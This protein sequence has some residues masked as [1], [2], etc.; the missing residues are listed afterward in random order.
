MQTSAEKSALE[1]CLR[2][3]AEQE[4]GAIPTVE[5]S[6]AS[7]AAELLFGFAQETLRWLTHH[8]YGARHERF[9]IELWRVQTLAFDAVSDICP[10]GRRWAKALQLQSADGD[11]LTVCVGDLSPVRLP[12]LRDLLDPEGELE[13][14]QIPTFAWNNRGSGCGAICADSTGL[15]RPSLSRWCAECRQTSSARRAARVTSIEKAFA[16]STSFLAW[17]DGRRIRVW[18]RRCSVCG[19]PFKTT[20]ANRQRCDPCH[21]SHR[22]RPRAPAHFSRL[23]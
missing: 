2:V 9:L 16:G 7:R 10:G 4:R 15:R 22:S 11:P 5:A 12:D 20:R 14:G 17:E 1:V 8:G 13:E 21:E 18:P 6:S 19:S 3:I 23:R